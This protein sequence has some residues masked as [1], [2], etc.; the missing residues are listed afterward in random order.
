MTTKERDAKI[1]SYGKAP[2]E[3]NRALRKFPKKMWKFKPG[4]NRWSVH[5]IIIH[6]AESEANSFV[7][8]RRFIAEPGSTVMGY[9][10]D[11][12][13]RKLDY[14]RQSTADAL[15]LFKYLR[16]CSY[17]LIKALPE[18]T[19]SATVQHSESGTMKFERWLEVYEEHTHKHIRQMQVNLEAWKKR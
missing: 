14:H 12:W 1:R 3:L 17:K 13:A 19:W 7:R 2:A 11:L 8:C 5:E 4:P 6:L 10:Q 18:E 16:T 15:E 9:D